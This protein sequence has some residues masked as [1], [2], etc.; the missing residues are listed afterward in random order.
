MKLELLIKKIYIYLA[1]LCLS[2]G[3]WDLQSLRQQIGSLVAAS[4]I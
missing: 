4:G 1:A 2:C 3:T